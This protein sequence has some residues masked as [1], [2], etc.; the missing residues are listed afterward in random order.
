MFGQLQ[1]EK[2]GVA[3]DQTSV[4]IATEYTSK[5]SG[6][7]SVLVTGTQ[8]GP[9]QPTVVQGT[10]SA[11][12]STSE[13]LT[14]PAMDSDTPP[15]VTRQLSMSEQYSQMEI[16]PLDTAVL[17]GKFSSDSSSSNGK[18]APRATDTRSKGKQREEKGAKSKSKDQS[19][20]KR[21]KS[22]V[23]SIMS[24]MDKPTPKPSD[25]DAMPP[26]NAVSTNVIL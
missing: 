2:R 6:Q 9:Q 23:E 13:T 15:G 22:L 18:Q 14:R 12:A 26:P 20:R 4:V 17:E 7:Y 25:A 24:D 11:E 21:E 8:P 16:D 3:S 10:T 5:A 1:A 19:Q